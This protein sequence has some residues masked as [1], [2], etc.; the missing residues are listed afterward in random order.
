MSRRI[1][2]LGDDPSGP[3]RNPWDTAPRLTP[4]SLEEYFAA[5]N[6]GAK[7]TR[8]ELKFFLSRIANEQVRLARCMPQVAEASTEA[9]MLYAEDI[10][11]RD[12]VRGRLR[13]MWQRFKLTLLLLQAR[14]WKPVEKPVEKEAQP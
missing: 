6:E 2:L 13:G 10:V 12:T 7:V 9:A 1:H 4:E 3:K 14:V 5:E 11:R 8:G